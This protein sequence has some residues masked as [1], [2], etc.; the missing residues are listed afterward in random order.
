V[1]ARADSD[2]SETLAR[3]A[4]D[5]LAKLKLPP[6][7]ENFELAYIY[8]GG[9]HAELKRAVDEVLAKS[10]MDAGTLSGLHN[11]FLRT[12]IG[13]DA[14]LEVGAKMATEFDALL[15]ALESAGKDHT[16]YGRT[17]SRASVQLASSKP[18]PDA[19]KFL[20]DQVVAATKDM[21]SRSKAL[22]QQLT[23][24]SREVNELH[25]HLESVRRESLT[26]PLTGIA[27]R[28]AFDI[29]FKERIQIAAEAKEPLSLAMCDIDHF[30]KFNDTWGHQTGDQVLKLVASCL[31]ENVK[32][33]DTAARFG[34]EEFAI[35][36]PD[37]P[38][39]GAMGL[40]NKIR[41]HVESKKLIK[42]STGDILGTITI[43]MGVAQ[44]AHA[45]SA[46][47]LIHRADACLYAAKRTGRNRVVG[48][49]DHAALSLSQAP[50][51]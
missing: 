36:L 49:S 23:A 9:A 44:L 6:T 3:S 33:R 21:E 51:A 39:N 32:G 34:G 2:R 10:A 7:P 16:S 46:E 11:R 25:Q 37:T 4:I 13:E 22:E 5:W 42:K 35:I 31:A 1:P 19:L 28:K 15:R 45:E 18:S 50:A 38:L 26:D 48:E 27:N 8:S 47:D 41:Y 43:S 40:A 14:M 24:S 30:K 29:A 20:I 12:S 17:L